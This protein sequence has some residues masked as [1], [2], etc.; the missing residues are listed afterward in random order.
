MGRVQLEEL[1]IV[2]E[3]SAFQINASIPYSIQLHSWMLQCTLILVNEF[4]VW[5]AWVCFAEIVYC[6]SD[7]VKWNHAQAERYS[8]SVDSRLSL[9]VQQDFCPTVSLPGPCRWGQARCLYLDCVGWRVTVQRV[10]FWLYNC[11]VVVFFWLESHFALLTNVIFFCFVIINAD[12][13]YLTLSISALLSPLSLSLPSFSL[14]PR[15]Q[16]RMRFYSLSTGPSKGS[17]TWPW[18]TRANTTWSSETC[19]SEC[20]INTHTDTHWCVE[21][22]RYSYLIGADSSSS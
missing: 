8:V 14:C 2:C 6:V 16:S 13:E 15:L 20:N 4:S 21:S 17:I 12:V 3:I 5:T 10:W 9:T 22:S 18:R 7:L 1:C 11:A 19:Y